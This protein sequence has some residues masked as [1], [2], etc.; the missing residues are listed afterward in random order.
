MPATQILILGDQGNGKSTS[1]E[2]V[3]HEETLVI[4]PNAKPF[5]WEGS[6]K[7]YIVGKN[8]IQTKELVQ[9]LPVLEKINKEM[10]HIKNILIEDLNHFYTARITSPSFMSRT[11]GNDAFAKWNEMAADIAR[12]IAIGDTFR[13]DLNIVYHAHT[14]MHDTGTIGL[15]SPGKLLDKDIKP[16]GFFTYVLHSVIMKSDKKIDYLFLTNRDG[17]YDAKSPKGCFKELLIPND[18]NTVI[19]R[20][21]EYQGN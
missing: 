2:S 3:N 18:M 13:D 15:L 10:P 8:R 16:A 11:V 7:Q 21:R 5:P 9:V 14:E 6:S 17:V 12:I 1:W 4:T 19:K 20:I